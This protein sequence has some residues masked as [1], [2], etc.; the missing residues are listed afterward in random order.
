MPSKIAKLW[1]SHLSMTTDPSAHVAYLTNGHQLEPGEQPIIWTK[2]L[3]KICKQD[4]KALVAHWR[5]IYERFRSERATP[6]GMVHHNAKITAKQFVIN[7]PNDI[8]DDEVH[9]L[10][11]A[12][13]QDFPRHIPVSMV[14]HRTSNR[15]KMHTHLQGLFS[16]RNGGYGSINDEFR[17]N[18]TSTMKWTV[19][20]EL[21]SIGYQVDMGTPGSINTR[22]QTWFGA[23]GTVEQRRNPRFLI[24]LAA[25]AVSP[26]IQAYCFKRAKAMTARMNAASSVDAVI[27]T[28]E[29][30]DQLLSIYPSKETKHL[31]EQSGTSQPHGTEPLTQEALEKALLKAKQWKRTKTI[32][33]NI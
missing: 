1:I 18:A 30:M 13:L 19:H 23:Q 22:E 21:T 7:L 14:L 6:G 9:K 8:S 33:Q 32:S 10:A 24:D 15:G 28:M 17:L 29:T 11:K 31:R 16:Y 12:V 25:K 20:K 3:P 27:T 2:S 26:R 5:G 4:R